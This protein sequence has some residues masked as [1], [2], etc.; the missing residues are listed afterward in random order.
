MEPLDNIHG[1]NPTNE[2]H[3]N[4]VLKACNSKVPHL[5][6]RKCLVTLC[7]MPNN[8]GKYPCPICRM[9]LN[10]DNVDMRDSVTNEVKKEKHTD[11]KHIKIKEDL[12][13]YDEL[14]KKNNYINIIK[15]I[16]II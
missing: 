9:P 10:C 7:S 12:V 11:K 5:L 8:M 4:A 1:P 2:H 6:H 13:E 15:I 16:K 14:I 3:D